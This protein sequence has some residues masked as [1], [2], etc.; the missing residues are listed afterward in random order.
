MLDSGRVLIVTSQV[1]PFKIVERESAHNGMRKMLNRKTN[2]APL[3]F[4]PNFFYPQFS[5]TSSEKETIK[6]IFCQNSISAKL[7]SNYQPIS[8]TIVRKTDSARN[9]RVTLTQKLPFN[10]QVY[11]TQAM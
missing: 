4:L 10:G 5:R 3:F 2:S 11:F 1:T 6:T 7:N 8:F 9:L